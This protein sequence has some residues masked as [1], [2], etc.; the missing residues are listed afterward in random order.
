MYAKRLGIELAKAKAIQTVQDF[1]LQ[2]LYES[3]VAI[4]NTILMWVDPEL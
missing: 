3:N 4:R 1:T 2:M